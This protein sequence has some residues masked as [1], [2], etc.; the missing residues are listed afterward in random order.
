MIPAEDL[1]P[2]EVH[3]GPIRAIFTKGELR[4]LC[5]GGKEIARRVYFAVRDDG[6]GTVTPVFTRS[7]LRE[8]DDGFTIRLEAECRSKSIDYSWK[9]TIHGA[10]TGEIT[11]LVEGTANRDFTSRRIGLCLL[12]GAGALSG[13]KFETLDE[14]GAGKEGEF[15]RLVAP[16]LLAENFRQLRYVTP[17]LMQVQ[18]AID[19][20]LFSM[21][22]QRNYGDS[23][24]KAFAPLSYKYPQ[25]PAGATTQERLTLAVLGA[26]RGKDSEPGPVRIRL[27]ATLPEARLP[28]I[29]EASGDAAAV[30]FAAINTKREAYAEKDKIT[31]A[32]NPATHLRD[33]DM[34]MENVPAVI[35]QVRTIRSFAP[36]A[37]IRIDPIGFNSRVAGAPSDSRNETDFGVAWSAAM[38]KALALAGVDEAAFAVDGDSAREVQRVFAAHAGA[39]LVEI[40][41]IPGSRPPIEPICIDENGRRS[42]WLVNLTDEI[43]PYALEGS[44]ISIPLQPWEVRPI[45]LPKR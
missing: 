16:A 42:L 22:D 30:A 1:P 45:E 4:Y 37:A 24:Y 25:V 8:N 11:F 12:Y 27:G 32:F 15:P 35:D 38:I 43:Q 31:F 9:G 13:Q 10:S 19:G 18:A 33:D 5:V 44:R 2:A 29:V 14:A 17:N 34:L 3:A 21:E 7:D 20:A 28:K 36:K 39:N 23:S 40:P 26:E 6:W 41:A